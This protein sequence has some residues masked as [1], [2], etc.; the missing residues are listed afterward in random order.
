MS[1]QLQADLKEISSNF[2]PSSWESRTLHNARI[3]LK[4]FEEMIAN[5]EAVSDAIELAHE[6]DEEQDQYKEGAE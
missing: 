2:N 6:I 1:T 3:K 4:C 5:H